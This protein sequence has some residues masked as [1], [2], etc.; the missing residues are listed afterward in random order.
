M[1]EASKA[2]ERRRYAENAAYRQ[3]KLEAA[4]KWRAENPD[5]VRNGL[6]SWKQRNPETV[7]RLRRRHQRQPEPT[8]M[9]P[10][11]CE[12]K[13]GRVAKALD[14]NHETGAFR[15]WLCTRC[16]AGIGLLGDTIKDLRRMALYLTGGDL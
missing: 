7:Q 14:H 13:C 10:E 1:S 4:R 9:R 6:R 11:F 3:R 16:N 15:G 12:A 5:K 8:R 2:A